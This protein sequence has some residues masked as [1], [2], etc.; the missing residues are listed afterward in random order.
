MEAVLI[1]S[2]KNLEN[3]EIRVENQT[4]R[5]KRAVKY[6]GLMLDNRPGFNVHAE[7]AGKKVSL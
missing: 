2:R 6:L 7:Y 5:S 1:A 3:I 4:L